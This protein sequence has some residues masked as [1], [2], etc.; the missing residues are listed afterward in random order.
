LLPGC[1]TV[2]A[3]L[4][5]GA[6]VSNAVLMAVAERTREIGVL[7]AVGASRGQIFRVFWLQTVQVCLAGAGV[8]VLTAFAASQGTEAWLRRQLPFAPTESLIHWHAWIVWVC[9]AS[10]L[11][12]GSVAGF[13]PAWRASTLSPIEAMRRRGGLA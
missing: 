9:L 13:L 2:V 10:A 1:L 3:L 5:A 4:V 11:V 7:R 6:G 12:L 8:G